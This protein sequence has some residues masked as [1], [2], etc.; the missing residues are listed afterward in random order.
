[1]AVARS[2]D[3]KLRQW[4]AQVVFSARGV[5][6]G[7]VDEVLAGLDS[8]EPDLQAV[9][10]ELQ[11]HGA[12]VATVNLVPR[13]ALRA[14]TGRRRL[15]CQGSDGAWAVLHNESGSTL[16]DRWQTGHV[17]R[18]TQ[19][20][21]SLI[22]ETVG[23]SRTP[24]LLLEPAE[25]MA[26]QKK[27][28]LAR[29]FA[30]LLRDRSDVVAVSLYA[31]G[32]GVL[33]L[34]TP[35]AVQAAVNSVAFGT[36]L[37]PLVVLS[38]LLVATLTF[39]ATLRGLQ[40]WVVEM[41]QRRLLVRTASD[42]SQR[43]HLATADAFRG[44]MP[45]E[46]MNRWF[47]VF[48]IQKGTASILL[49]GLEL[50]LTATVGLLVLAFYHPLLLAFDLVLLVAVLA[51]AVVVGRGAIGSSIAESKSK[52]DIAG[53]L[54]DAAMQSA[55]W[56]SRSGGRLLRTRTEHFVRRY[57]RARGR[58][59]RILFRQVVVALALEVVASA[60][61]LGLG[62]YLV[63]KG[64]LSLGQLVAAELIVTAIVAAI[65]KLAKHLETFYDLVA[66]SDKLQTLYDIPCHAPKADFRLAEPD[67]EK[68]LLETEGVQ[69]RLLDAGHRTESTVGIEDTSLPFCGFRRVAVSSK[70]TAT[71]AALVLAGTVAPA[72]GVLRFAGIPLRDWPPP[73]RNE[74]IALLDG[75]QMVSASLRENLILGLDD[76][77]DTD[78][79]R[80]LEVV[81]LRRRIESLADGLDTPFV[82]A[83]PALHPAEQRLFVLARCILQDPYV[84]VINACSLRITKDRQP[85][86]LAVAREL[87]GSRLVLWIDRQADVDE[88]DPNQCIRFVE[89]VTS[90]ALGVVEGAA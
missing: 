79:W 32:V 15:L 16:F 76:T 33:S 24:W 90:D 84:L 72:S 26:E 27:S 56:K 46:R 68:P 8:A 67:P 62:G 19:P 52:Y 87:S 41:L 17:E 69:V 49:G 20:K 39:S 18:S 85:Q 31:I 7:A 23:R 50:L 59:F 74:S 29:L 36:L 83:L 21:A 54:Q 38:L 35:I 75:V 77:L 81:G 11:K 63:I 71:A 10:K 5:A 64:Q 43:L 60:G 13:Q 3:E 25:P 14:T 6:G 61:I 73:R 9:R 70:A 40:A 58:H 44:H 82:P 30:P 28:R 53:W 12:N 88:P 48:L 57:L 86:W 66:S 51:I 80:A 42:V 2:S 78:I 4:L 55:L 22:A 47:E 37:Q 65:A 45:Y 1:M 34:A 89:P